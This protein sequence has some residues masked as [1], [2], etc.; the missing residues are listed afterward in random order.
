V[1]VYDV[2]LD[3]IFCVR[4][5]RCD[6]LRG[7]VFSRFF[8]FY[9]C[10][11]HKNNDDVVRV[12]W[13]LNELYNIY[14]YKKK[15]NNYFIRIGYSDARL[16]DLIESNNIILSVD[17]RSDYNIIV[18]AVA[19]RWR[20]RDDNCLETRRVM[21]RYR[22]EERERERERESEIFSF[23][24]RSTILRGR[25]RL[26]VDIIIIIYYSTHSAGRSVPVQPVGVQAQE[27]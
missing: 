16:T 5:N 20:R 12:V 10:Q 15:N 17:R 21:E 22:A 11:R 26:S 25:A 24:F 8:Y 19:C 13:D 23:R 4:H 7:R 3:R 1:C 9:F 18:P 27:R 6:R 2:L 14:I